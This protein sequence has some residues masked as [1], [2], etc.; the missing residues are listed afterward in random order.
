VDFANLLLGGRCNLRCPACIGQRLPAEER[1]STLDSFPPPGLDRF[2]EELRAHGVRELSLSGTSTDP[3]L[4]RHHGALLG[5]L[6]AE[7]PGVRLSLH[8]NGVLAL[9]ELPLVRRYDR[10]TVSIPSFDPRPY[11]RLT[12]SSRRP[13]DLA[14]LVA[15][16]GI[17]IKL[18]VLCVEE[19]LPELPAIA[20]RCQAIGIRRLVLR[21]PYGERAPGWEA[22]IRG[23]LGIETL[24]CR[25]VH[26][27]N[28]VYD[29]GGLELTLWDF[30]R[31]TLGCL[32]LLPSGAITSEY[33]L[34]RAAPPRAVA[35]CFTPSRASS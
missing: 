19:N 23:V 18:S 33:L 21:R 10:A 14:R 35:A 31:A 32:S 25:G 5:R 26:G 8:T 34:V 27:G 1:R 9:A 17:P 3:L 6:R 28:L 29:R 2:L 12:G 13:P 11:R 24:T 30:G 16:A 20:R 15:A 4:Y 7:L 22:R